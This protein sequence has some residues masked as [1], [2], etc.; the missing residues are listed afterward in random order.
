MSHAPRNLVLCCDGTSNQF[1]PQ[2]TSVVRLAQSLV[3]DSPCQR[4]YYDPGIGTLPEPGIVLFK[5]IWT[6]LALAFG[7]DLKWKVQEAYSYL[8]DMWEPGDRV[9][10]FGFSRGAYTVRVLAGMVHA[11][12]LLPRGNQN[13][14]PYA[15]RIFQSARRE[16]RREE[17]NGSGW[18]ELCRDFRRTFSRP[19]FKHDNERRFPVHFL[20]IWDTVSSVGWVWNPK[21]YFYTLHNPSIRTIRHAI[22]VDERRTFFRQNRME[23]EGAQDF[24]EL[25]FPGVHCD[26][27]GGYPEREGGLWREPFEWIMAEAEHSDLLID[28][29]R[30]K[31]V[32]TKTPSSP[33]PWLDPAHESLTPAWWPVEF[34]PKWQQV[35]NSQR[36]RLR[37]NRGRPR[38]IQNGALLD[39]TTLLRICGGKY[40]PP[41][42]TAAFRDFVRKL[43]EIPHELPYDPAPGQPKAELVARAVPTQ[44]L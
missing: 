39:K 19:V 15:F 1:G 34:L 13:L 22:S 25:W 33:K 23:P 29:D 3:R 30:L 26:V 42:M 31:E 20:G 8:M 28:Q 17:E 35:P 7:I 32:L 4:L 5:K 2:N 40:E 41:N 43:P 38:F 36:R 14:V 10:L 6:A 44:P 37:W 9:F 11:L 21:T 18:W 27:G 16:R 24:K 12:G